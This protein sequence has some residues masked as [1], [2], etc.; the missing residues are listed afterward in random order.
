MWMALKVVT[1][2]DI[3]TL[4]GRKLLQRVY[5]LQS[6]NHLQDHY[7]WPRDPPGDISPAMLAIWQNAFKASIMDPY[8]PSSSRGLQISKWVQAWTD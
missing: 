3:A 4:D 7:D 8:A 6:G 1:I 5:L 2:A